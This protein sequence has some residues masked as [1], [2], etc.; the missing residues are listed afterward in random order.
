MKYI[1]EMVH[2]L[3][4]IKQHTRNMHLNHPQKNEYSYCQRSTTFP[5]SF[6]GANC[7]FFCLENRYIGFLIRYFF[8]LFIV[9]SFAGDDKKILQVGVYSCT[10]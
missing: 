2:K 7:M 3:Q 8:Y 1:K 5:E 4:S 9:A 10:V 6:L